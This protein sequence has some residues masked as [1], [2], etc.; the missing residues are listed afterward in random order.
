MTRVAQGIGL[1]TLA[2]VLALL[3]RN[4]LAIPA[5]VPLDPNEGWMAAHV[6]RLLA[7]GP[8]Y[9]PPSSL[10][11][12]NYP[13]LSFYP[14]AALTRLTGDAVVAGRLLAFASFLLLCG[15]IVAVARRLGAGWFGAGAGTLF[16]AATLLIASDYVGIADPQML[17]HAVQMAALL[18]V[19][20]DRV[21]AAALLFAVSLFVKHNLLALPLACG[22]WLPPRDRRAGLRFIVSGLVFAGAGLAA[23]QIAF[24]AGLWSYLAT[25]RQSSPDNLWTAIAHLWW[26]LLPLPALWHAR[27][28]LR[29]YAV[30]ALLLGLAFSAGDGVDAN[31]FFDLAI[32]LSL[33]LSMCSPPPASA[34][35]QAFDAMHRPPLLAALAPLPLLAFLA[36]HF[37]DNNFFFTRAFAAQSKAD[38]AFLRTRPGPALCSQLSLCLWAGKTAE[39]DVFNIGEA[40]QAHARDPAALTRQIAAHRFPVIQLDDT[41]ALGPQVEAAIA[42]AYRRHHADDNG[43]W[44]TP[45]P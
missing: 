13:P 9:P 10:M 28:L 24:G 31:A 7:G 16:F 21:L 3:A 19:L 18:L 12:N 38:I 2:V 30:L 45:A 14:V 35:A 11:V 41:A 23:F 29:I 8:L 33:A 27:R 32:A 17:G 25:P 40:F 34:S 36:L 15:G 6:L 5:P 44:F 4:A 39:V 37:D 1:L 26:A 42:H 20:R 43:A 22:L